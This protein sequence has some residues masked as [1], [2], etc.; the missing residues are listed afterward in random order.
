MSTLKTGGC[1]LLTLALIGCRPIT[2]ERIT[3][4]E[5]GAETCPPEI[6]E[7]VKLAAA[8]AAITIPPGL[9]RAESFS[10]AVAGRRVVISL[11]PG[12]AAAGLHLVSNA[13]TITTFGGTLE[14]MADVNENAGAVAKGRHDRPRFTQHDGPGITQ[15]SDARAIEVSSGR[16][17]ITPFVIGTTL[18]PQTVSLDLLVTPGGSPLD[19][20]VVV[21]EAM[22]DPQLRPLSPD[23]VAIFL[24]PLR[25]FTMYDQV[26]AA[27]SLD[28]AASRPRAARQQWSCSAQSRFTLV[29]RNAT[30]PNLWD[31]RRSAEYGRSEWWLA[32][33][34]AKAGPFRAIFTSPADASGFATWLRQTHALHVGAYDVGVFRPE[35]SRDARRTVPASHSVADTYR[36]VSTDDLDALIVGRLGEP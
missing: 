18:R 29:D 25:H 1:L 34:S 32:L 35:Y 36:T 15:I 10:N 7:Q 26:E 6:Q 27:L 12:A 13:I 11:S 16:L 9:S 31:L 2:P 14:G 17:R 8:A 33:S 28:F 30:A 5:P 19:E 20:M 3:A 23:R 4:G 21:T 22:W 24:A